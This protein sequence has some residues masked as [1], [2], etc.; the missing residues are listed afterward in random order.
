[1]PNR[2]VFKWSELLIMSAA[3]GLTVSLILDER[4]MGK[5][6]ESELI[7]NLNDVQLVEINSKCFYSMVL[8]YNRL[9]FIS[10]GLSSIQALVFL[11]FTWN[12]SFPQLEL[13]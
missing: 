7:N 10:E 11:L 3:I 1:M 4:N 12:P 5:T 13:T 8:Y 6:G 2:Q 9:C